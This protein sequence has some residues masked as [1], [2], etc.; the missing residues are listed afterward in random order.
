MK[1]IILFGLIFSNFIETLG[2]KKL[3]I[4]GKM[5]KF[6]GNKAKGRISKHRCFNKTKHAKFLKNNHFLPPHTHTYGGKKC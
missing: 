6:V 2:V 4:S 1:Q 5:W 3:L